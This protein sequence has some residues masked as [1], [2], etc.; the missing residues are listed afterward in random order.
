MKTYFITGATGYIGSALIKFFLKDGQTVGGNSET[1]IIAPI[2][3]LYKASRMF[4]VGVQF[5]QA[6]LCD[7]RC[8]EQLLEV[9]RSVDYIFTALLLLRLLK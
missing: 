9:G 1:Q 6:D 4:P 3:D 8:I 2:R 7:K 5:L